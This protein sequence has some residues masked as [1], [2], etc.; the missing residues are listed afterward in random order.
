MNRD[1]ERAPDLFPAPHAVLEA[2]FLQ[3]PVDCALQTSLRQGTHHRGSSSTRD[4]DPKGLL[5]RFPEI[6]CSSRGSKWMTPRVKEAQVVWMD[7]V[8]RTESDGCVIGLG[9]VLQARTRGESAR[10]AVVRL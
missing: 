8:S 3:T 1:P 5:L 2:E 7:N 6:F 4:H 10:G 9:H